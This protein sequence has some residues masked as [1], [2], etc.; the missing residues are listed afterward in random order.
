MG[1]VAQ[2]RHRQGQMRHKHRAQTGEAEK[3]V[4]HKETDRTLTARKALLAV[5]GA[6]PPILLHVGG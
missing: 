2:R 6:F 3:D 4:S 5:G 1:K